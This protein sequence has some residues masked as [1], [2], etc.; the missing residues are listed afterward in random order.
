MKGNYVIQDGISNNN[1][2]YLYY[3]VI[4]FLS[5]MFCISFIC[6]S[7]NYLLN[8]KK[9]KQEVFIEGNG[10]GIMNII[11]NDIKFIFDSNPNLSKTSLIKNHTIIKKQGYSNNSVIGNILS[12]NRNG[13]NIIVD[14]QPIASLVHSI[15]NKNFFYKIVFNGNTIISNIEDREFIYSK[16]RQ[17][18]AENSITIKLDYRPTSLYLQKYREE[19][20]NQFLVVLSALV[21]GILLT[22][23]ILFYF[24]GKIYKLKA[25]NIELLVAHKAAQLNMDYIKSCQQLEQQNKLPLIL[26]VRSHNTNNVDL[27]LMMEELKTYT[28]AYTARCRYKFELELISEVKFLQINFDE[29]IL[30]QLIISL[31]YNILYFMRGANHIK[32][33]SVKFNQDSISF[34][35]DS[36]AANEE[37]MINWSKGL[38]QHLTNPYILDCQGV[39]QLIK[40]C[41]LDYKIIP[42]QGKNEIIIFL[43]QKQEVGRVIRFKS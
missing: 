26:S 18:N 23:P 2:D 17:I 10:E 35:Y 30:K 32:R 37:H 4:G 5:L 25:A 28:L 13:E 20:N 31:L 3:Y 9:E 39:F 16:T 22:V 27:L 24:T 42:D 8:V 21:L 15:L 33:F 41:K 19:F 29:V 14:L 1:R 34:I 12:V 6:F 40:N 38:F 36:F 43:E 11:T 7:Y